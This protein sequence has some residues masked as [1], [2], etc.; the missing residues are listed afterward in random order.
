MKK[1][2]INWNKI[3]KRVRKLQIRIAKA[4]SENKW[5]KV[6][7]LS[8]LL[9]NSFYAK[10]LAILKVVTNKGK[11]TAGVDKEIWTKEDIISKTKILNRRGYRP[12][13]LKRIYIPKKNGKKRPLGIPT[14]KDR[15][16]QALHLL[17]LEPIS[18]QLADINS[19]AFR[20]NRAARDAQSQVFKSLSQRTC[21]SF[22]FEADIKGCFD[23]IDHDW[24]LEN[25][26]M[27][28]QILRKWLKA[29]YIEGK[30]L[31]ATK[32]GT[33]QG[34]IIS[35][36]LM[37]LTLDGLE[38][39][40]KQ[41]F[42]KWKTGHKVNFIRYADDF[43]ITAASQ[44]IIKNEIKPLVI[45][46]LKQRGLSL[47]V[48]KT[49][50][51]NIKD[52]FDFLSQ[53]TRKYS[54]DKLLQKP[55]KKAIK[56][57]KL[58]L[59]KEVSRN[60]GKSPIVLIYQL[61]SILR[62]WT[63]YHKHIVSKEVFKEIDFYLWRLLGRWTKR[64]HQNKSWKWITAKYF[65]ASQE[66]SSF[67]AIGK[68]KNGKYLKIYKIFRAGKVPIIRHIKIKSAANPYVREDNKYFAMRRKDLRIKSEKTKQI[69]I[70]R[71]AYNDID[72]TL[73]NLWLQKA[74]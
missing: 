40:V 12:L 18:E 33:P 30:N 56:E 21:A 46:F 14:M 54:N 2:K 63:N 72:K 9:T 71:K 70:F 49:K 29:G 8:K 22:V 15:A 52:G 27:D 43:V 25:I 66:N 47:S 26:P 45:G 62:G 24:L 37:N 64:R 42:P 55:A 74:G 48:E 39:A 44:E 20:Q 65:S 41:K 67:S 16:M 59:K 19:Y 60:L 57:I 68:T 32:K 38:K 36:T 35:P 1:I 73:L 69:C 50:I 61:N 58:K 28:K 4:L 7:S 5:R 3:R 31:H 10:Q 53:N 34:G 6:K 51:T 13:P 23:Y 17:A 11:K